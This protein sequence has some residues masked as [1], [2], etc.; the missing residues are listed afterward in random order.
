MFN[1]NRLNNVVAGVTVLEPR[2]W[3]HVALVRVGSNVKVYLDGDPS[4]EID[5]KLA[6]G[7]V[8]GEEQIFVGGRSDNFAN[9]KGRIDEVAVYRRADSR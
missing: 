6:P 9:F 8:E 7:F 5:G 3:H 4:P 1:G 2:T